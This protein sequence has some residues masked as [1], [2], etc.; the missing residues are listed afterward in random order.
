MYFNSNPLPLVFPYDRAPGYDQSHVAAAKPRV[1]ALAFNESMVNLLN[2]QPATVV[3]TLN[4]SSASID[5]VLGP[6]CGSNG[7]TGINCIT[8][9]SVVETKTEATMAVAFRFKFVTGAGSFGI[10]GIIKT[11]DATGY[12]FGLYYDDGTT[13]STPG[14]FVESKGGAFGVRFVNLPL[15]VAGVPYFIA[16][17]IGN[18]GTI[19]SAD[20]VL[21]DMDSGQ[22]W[23]DSVA[24]LGVNSANNVADSGD[25]VVGAFSSTQ[26]ATALRGDFGA[27]MVSAARMSEAYL[28]L[29][30]QDLWSYWYQD[31]DDDL[32]LSEFVGV[33]DELFAQA[34]M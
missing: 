22:V 25:V 7:T 15:P 27:A 11:G 23:S 20:V 19:A 29:W 32:A 9:K 3:D 18:V 26:Y 30:A 28:L 14:Y 4:N 13:T 12:G 1:C 33:T 5:G 16:V 2:G 10:H 6:V 31:V 8:I 24:T 17:T 21:V 34:V